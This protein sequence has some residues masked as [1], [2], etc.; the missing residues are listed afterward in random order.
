MEPAEVI[1][2]TR[3]SILFSNGWIA[4]EWRDRLRGL[5]G[6]RSLPGDEGLVIRPCES[7]H[8]LWMRFPIDVV[9]A[10]PKKRVVRVYPN[11][12]PWRLRLGG[13]NAFIVI[14]GAAGMIERSGTEV[15]DTLEIRA[16]HTTQS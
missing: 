5:M 3:R 14:E 12:K 9:F 2:Q 1:N 6:R 8:T 13:W 4:L 7:I 11:V 15:G 16:P 10:D